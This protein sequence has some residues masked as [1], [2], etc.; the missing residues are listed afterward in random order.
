M[1]VAEPSPHIELFEHAGWVELRLNRPEKRN[2][3]TI[4]MIDDIL[5]KLDDEIAAGRPVVLLSAVGPIFCAGAD[6]KDRGSGQ[7]PS[8]SERLLQGLLAKRVVVIAEVSAP[9]LGA[10]VALLSCCTLVVCSDD[11]W[12]ALPEGRLGF[13]PAPMAAY[14]QD[15]MPIRMLMNLALGETKLSA[16]EAAAVGLVSFALPRDEVRARA[17]AMVERAV[18]E[19][20]LFQGAR[21]Y[22]QARFL[23]RRKQQVPMNVREET[24]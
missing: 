24:T 5:H 1:T 20:A 10:G 9:V 13:F 3:L 6:L 16:V 4:A 8:P 23:G 12:F 7:G 19:P 15:E 18:A 14:I 17:L 2:A 22:W 11:C 21:E